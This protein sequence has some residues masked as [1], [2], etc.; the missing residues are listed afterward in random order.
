MNNKSIYNPL[1]TEVKTGFKGTMYVVG[2]KETKKFDEEVIS[3][4]IEIYPFLE[5]VV[6]VKEEKE[7]KKAKKK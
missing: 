4:F 5:V 6:E 7:V 2:P 3:R 1:D